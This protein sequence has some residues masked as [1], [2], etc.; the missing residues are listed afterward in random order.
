VGDAADLVLVPGEYPA[1]A[2]M[3][4]PGDRT[5]IRGGR[6]VAQAGDLL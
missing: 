5:V 3:D 1:S 4:R 2:V 6:I